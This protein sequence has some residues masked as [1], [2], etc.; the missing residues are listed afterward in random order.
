MLGFRQKFYQASKGN[1]ARVRGRRSARLTLEVLEA[2][3]V[4][5]SWN[6]VG[7]ASVWDWTL[8]ATV[9]GR[10]DAIA[11][12]PNFNG[13]GTPAMFL[14]TANGGVWRSTDFASSSP[15]WTPLTDHVSDRLGVPPEQQVGILSIGALT[16]DP[17]HPNILYA[18]TG[19]FLWGAPSAGI[20]KSVDGGNS[21]QLLGQNPFAQSYWGP[22]KLVVDPT[23]VSGNTIYASSAT[24]IYRS[25]DGGASWQLKVNGLPDGVGVSDLEYTLTQPSPSQPVTLSVYA[26]VN[27]AP[28]SARGVW[29][30]NPAGDDTWHQMAINLVDHHTGQVLGPE[31]IGT[32][33][34]TADHTIGPSPRAYAVITDAVPKPDEPFQGAFLVLNVFG[35]YAGS[36]TWLPASN[37]PYAITQGGYSQSIGLAPDQSIFVGAIGTFKSVDGGNHWAD[38]GVGTNGV[39]THVDSHAWA[40]FGGQVYAGNDGGI[41]RYNPQPWTV[42]G[43]PSGGWW[44]LNTT[45]LQ[46]LLV[47]GASQHPTN[48]NVILAEAQDNGDI[49]RSSTGAW[50]YTGGSDGGHVWF[51]PDPRGG[52]QYAYKVD[53]FGRLYRSDDGGRS[54]SREVDPYPV[55]ATSPFTLDPSNT[56]RLLLG[57]SRVYDDHGVLIQRSRLY[58]SPDRGNHWNLISQELDDGS[59]SALAYAPGNDNVIY[60]AYETGK[61]FRTTN[62]VTWTEVDQGTSWGAEVTQIA[63]DPSNEATAYLTTNHGINVPSRVWRTLNGGA[64]WQEITGDLPRLAI[65]ALALDHTASAT[66]PTLWVA[67]SVGVYGSDRQG[68]NTHWA[69]YGS[70]LPNVPVSVLEFNRRS[71]VLTAGTWGRSVWQIA[72]PDIVT[73]D[74]ALASA[75]RSDNLFVFAKSLD[76]RVVFNQA[77]PGGAFVGWQEVPGGV[78]TDAPLAAG[79]QANTLFVFAKD[80]DGRV[81]F[82]QAAPGGAF[83]GWQE[84]PGGVRT[85]AALASAGRSDNLFVFA[86]GLDG[87]VLFNQAAPGGAFVG[88]QEVPGGVRTDAPLAAGMQANT[89][90][91]FAKGLDGRV[92]FNQAAPGGA[93][94]GWQEVPGGVRTDVALASAGRSDNLFVFAKGLDG[95]VL[96][97]QAAPGGAFVG[98]QEVPGDV[99][100][101]SALAAGMQANTLF[102]FA[103]TAGGRV[104]FNQAAPGGAFVGWQS[105]SGDR[106]QFLVR[107]GVL[108][109]DGDQP[110]NRNDMI[111]LDV[112]GGGV[113]ATLDGEV[114]QFDPGEIRSVVVNPG[115]GTNTINVLRTLPG[116]PV[117][118]NSTGIDMVNVGNAANTMN[119]IL[120]IVTVNGQGGNT[121]LNLNNQGEGYPNGFYYNLYADRVE[122]GRGDG[123]AFG[124]DGPFLFPPLYYRGVARLVLNGPNKPSSG[125]SF[126]LRGMPAGTQMTI[127]GGTYG[128]LIHAQLGT[129]LPNYWQFTGPNA[130]TLND[131]VTFTGMSYLLG[132]GAVPETVAFR[133]GS[134][135]GV[136]SMSSSAPNVLDLSA[137]DRDV[138][139]SLVARTIGGDVWQG[140]VP[141]VID[142]FRFVP[143][144]I[145]SAGNNTLIGQDAATTWTVT[146]S[147]TGDV[148]SVHGN[149]HFSG[150]ANLVGGSGGNTFNVQSTTAGRTLTLNAG[151]GSNTVN[152]GNAANTMNDIL[153][154][155]TVN[156]Q[157]GTTT[158]NLNNQGEGYPNGFYYNIYADRVEPGRGDGRA[159]GGEGPYLFPP[160]YY[161]GVTRLVLNS[162]NRP[163]S[164]SSIYVRGTAAAT[165]MTINGSSY[166]SLIMAPVS[167]TGRNYWQLTGPNAGTLNDNVTFTGMTYLLASWEGTEVFAF[168]P[169]GSLVRLSASPLANDT[170]DF[171]AYGRDIT[172]SLVAMT[173]GGDVW[174]GQVPG[175]IDSFRY[176]PTII[177]SAGNDT[178][179]GQDAATT[180]TVTGTNTGDV[181]SVHGNVHFS[182]FANF[183]GGSDADVF[184]FRDGGS[185]FGRIDG[186]GGTN[187][188]DYSAYTGNV[189]VNLQTGTATGVG[190]SIA[191]IQN[192]TGGNGGPVGSYN[193]L[194]GSGG[195]VLTGGNGRR[196]LLIAGAA[197]ST[198]LGGDDEDL[199]I[200]GTTAYDMDLASLQA[201]LD[202]WTRTDED[203]DTRV[204]N[205]THG[206]GVPLLDATTVFGNGGGNSLR[207]GSGRDL[208][209]GNLSLDTSDWDPLSETFISV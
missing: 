41:W 207:G 17:N 86:K 94:V 110:V 27:T 116:V 90:F 57:P 136:L 7:P 26:G 173:L 203:Y 197:V 151:A 101:D 18:G 15:T 4:L 78:R 169:G 103:K 124:G 111:T 63:V 176:I 153:G 132:S 88:W 52:G 159:F 23:D 106:P 185:V 156:G 209:F 190:G 138:T 180:W 22:T 77:A 67:T 54:F 33:N 154:V 147:N 84:V 117:T 31:H 161:R 79:M 175:V 98:W 75:G 160:L 70:G 150:F 194:V 51:D 140:K 48:P 130:G 145:G 120:G 107:D 28:A 133:P 53:A 181:D 157:G 35:L 108:A 64:T 25:R 99:R 162:P 89:L 178:L 10:V 6:P 69:P 141:G 166:G 182:G 59:I 109:I 29:R 2:R 71:R 172:V 123:R 128:S 134:S 72:V 87:R 24:G 152:V 49:L 76:G 95:R 32:I 19:D 73:T 9:S 155:L 146:G 143:T 158:L 100:T 189:L 135:L 204:F 97:N 30:L 61:L 119:D 121:T 102:V 206:L 92:L 85:N 184:R 125:S 40:F 164:G 195:N 126:Y 179:I 191:N 165:Q 115:V 66:S 105:L 114:A 42:D 82:N 112:Q 93:F 149:V 46:T 122:P 170:L 201:L 137:Y 104:L 55:P 12:S 200:G 37:F 183:I 129:G 1:R 205:L 36:Q 163:S 196:N 58:E 81:L 60:V 65:Q 144:I 142:Y 39:T 11:I 5:S 50:S 43:L 127:Y 74:V 118:I 208:F 198:L 91:V 96:F 177:G 47:N 34:L 45:G 202:E 80:L 167:P 187:T 8:R 171:S 68:T 174:Q 44:S 13:L 20:L 131:N 113:R 148:D 188:L 168:R 3:T 38:I 199:L 16:V 186:G 21:W 139:V 62:R 56:S 83:V 192:V 14:G 193:L